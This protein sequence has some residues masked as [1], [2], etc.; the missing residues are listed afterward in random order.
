[1]KRVVYTNHKSLQYILDKKEL[2]MRQRRWIELL[3]DY[4][5]EI[6][7]QPGKAN[8]VADALSRN[9]RQ[10]I[11]VR[12]LVMTI[13]PSLHE[14][15]HNAQSKAM[16]M[17]NVEADNLGKLIKQIFKIHPDGTRYHDK[18]IWL[19]KFGR[20]RD[21]ILHESHKSKYSI[22]P[23]SDKM[24]QDLKQLYWWLNMKA[25]IST[26]VSKCLTCAKERINMDFIV[27]L[28]RTSSGYDSI[29]IIVD[30]LTKSAHFLLVKTTD[31]MEKLTQLYLKEIVF[32]HGVPIS[33]ISDRDS[34]FTSRFWQSLHEAL[35]TRLEISIAYQPETDGQS[36]RTI[37]TLEDM[38]R[39]C[40][41]DFEG[42]WD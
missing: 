2:N 42:S 23:G 25:D 9:E 27:G 31:S 26:Y 36:K 28:P 32:W 10:P 3:S 5:Y 16:K 15:I 24:Y 41:I 1:M 6:C 40:V 19:P 29:W 35:G 8:V 33:I 13:H 34:K 18:R 30:R 4:D 20:L 12:E 39:A 14:Q 11:R 38:F 21:L 37:Q 7:Y 22:L 17:R